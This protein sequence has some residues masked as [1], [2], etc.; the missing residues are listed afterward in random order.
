MHIAQ[1]G[2]GSLVV[3]CHG[4][5]E[6]WYSWRHQL[7]A[8]SEAGYHVLAPDQRGC[9]QTDRLELIEAYN[10]L[11]LTADIVGLVD[12]LNQEQA[13]IAGMTGGCCYPVL[14]P[15]KTRHF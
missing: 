3:L 9:G 15:V 2:S 4:F 10:I 7:T 8:L 6:S 1:Q 11:E 14:R 12:T 5:P 13:V